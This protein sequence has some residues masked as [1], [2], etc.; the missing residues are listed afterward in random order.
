MLTGKASQ[1]R[2]VVEEYWTDDLVESVYR[3]N[4]LRLPEEFRDAAHEIFA[5]RGRLFLTGS[6]RQALLALLRALQERES[7]TH[8]LLSS[9]NCAVVRDAVIKAGLVAETFD[10]ASPTGRID[11]GAIGEKLTDRHL[12][13]VVPHLFGVPSDFRPLIP[14]AQK[15]G[16]SI[17]EDC[18]HTLGGMIGGATTGT[19]G[20]ASIFSFNYD[21][22]ISLAGGGLLLVNDSK[23]GID[24]DAFG[25]VPEPDSEYREFRRL[26]R[27]LR[28]RRSPRPHP[29][30][31]AR[32]GNRLGV[33]PYSKPEIPSGIGPLRAAIGLTQIAGYAAI[34][35]ER[36]A[37]AAILTKAAGRT[38]WHVDKDVG[39][40]YL[41]QRLL[42][43]VERTVE[44]IKSCRR[45]G[46]LAG[47]FNW[48]RI[49]DPSE[50]AHR[51]N[52]TRAARDGVNFPIHQ[53]LDSAHLRF[54]ADR[55]HE[56][57]TDEPR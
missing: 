35:E 51:P 18:S 17:V 7:R 21:K 24:A 37:N 9:F 15:M 19:I 13:V 47:N 28:H 31:V 27:F 1:L 48:D 29:Q 46:I 10:L 34:V 43:G 12:A 54:L 42:V 5:R 55:Y 14:H 26:S 33:E 4:K 25:P 22:P 32:I 57:S 30:L 41:K 16:V 38:E 40:A 11:W 45:S 36:N 20:D 23:I 50:A 8:V 39:P 3:G 49:I 6:G 53:N 2:D 44:I 56:T 52:A